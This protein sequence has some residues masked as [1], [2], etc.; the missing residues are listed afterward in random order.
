[1]V[2][3]SFSPLV[4]R[5]K[6]YL[7]ATDMVLP[8]LNLSPSG[9]IVP[10][11]FCF[12]PQERG[13]APF[14]K[15]LRRL[16]E[17]TFA[18]LGMPM[19]EWVFYDCAVMPG[20]VFGVSVDSA[21]LE[22]WVRAVMQVEPDYQG[23]IPVSMFIAIPMLEPGSWFVYTLCDINGVAPGAG[24]SGIRQFT[25][26][27]GLDV[28]PM[29]RLYGT[30]QWRSTTVREV[31]RLGALELVTAYTPAHS[32]RRTFTYRVDLDVAKRKQVLSDEPDEGGVPVA[33]HLL[34]VDNEDMLRKL[35]KEL[36]AGVR[37]EIV[38]AP[39]R[40]GAHTQIP[41]RRCDEDGKGAWS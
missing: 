21:D 12:N 5:T 27:L 17:L 30:L 25:F 9:V 11:E 2:A 8:K 1:M 19:P 24:P 40:K 37:W 22:P 13:N 15:M 10:K 38:G 14:L 41:L 6:P 29:K 16:D 20:A 33:S 36:E 26:G 32:Y 23:P 28:F 39:F 31:V 18:P 34:D 7:V 3:M 35:Q 4:D